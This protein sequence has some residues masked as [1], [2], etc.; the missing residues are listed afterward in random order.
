[1]SA[2]EPTQIWWTADELSEAGLPD[3]PGSK[4]GINSIADRQGWRF[5]EG[6]AK[7]KVG[8]GG[9]WKYHW[10]VL[11]LAARS[12]LLKD[13]AENGKEIK[14][15]PPTHGFGHTFVRSH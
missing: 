4:R 13:A 3:L 11:P 12:K 10:S 9:G 7:R 6:C 8:R 14:P 15:Q 2:L 1:M 5:I